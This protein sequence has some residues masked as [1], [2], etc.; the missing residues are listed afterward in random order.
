MQATGVAGAQA[1]FAFFKWDVEVVHGVVA[2]CIVD[3]SFEPSP[4]FQGIGREVEDHAEAAV[5]Q[6]CYVR[7]HEGVDAVGKKVNGPW[8]D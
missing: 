3:Q 8:H 7:D 2:P 5:Q 6:G 4:L 1:F